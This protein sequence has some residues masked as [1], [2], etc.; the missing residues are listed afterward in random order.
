M[1]RKSHWE[2]VYSSKSH[3]EVSWYTEHIESSLTLI[4]R[5]GILKSASII[6]IGGGASTLPDDLIKK[7]YGNISIVDISGSALEIAKSRLGEESKK[8]TWIED[9]ILISNFNLQSFDVWHDR[10]VFHFLTDENDRIRYRENLLHHVKAG[11][12]AIFSVFA[13]DGPL[14]CSMLEVK[15][16]NETEII[17]FFS[18]GFEAVYSD[19]VVHN[20]PS[21]VEQRFVN[22]ILKRKNG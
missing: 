14:K 18:T 19:R 13:D 12:F 20:T 10:A 17:Q 7:G 22:V 4:E 1:D 21:G 6:D 5:T 8:I 11:G 2:K 3:K 16:H 9:D 15:R